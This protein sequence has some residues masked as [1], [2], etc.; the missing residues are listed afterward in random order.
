MARL[1]PEAGFLLSSLGPRA[2][3]IAG[4]VVWFA[5]GEFCTDESRLGPRILVGVG[6]RL[7]TSDAVH[8][9]AVSLEKPARVVGRLPESIARDA[10][11]YVT[12]NRDVLR[13]YWDSSMSTE[14]ALDLLVAV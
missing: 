10:V 1:D 9:A 5:A 11:A 3:G 2:T 8:A 13:R 7:S 14:A 12:R 4:A 6:D